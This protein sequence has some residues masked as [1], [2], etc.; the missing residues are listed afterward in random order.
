[1]QPSSFHLPKHASY[2]VTGCT[3]TALAF[4]FRGSRPTLSTARSPDLQG[5][6]IPQSAQRPPGR[7]FRWSVW[8]TLEGLT[9]D[10]GTPQVSRQDS[11]LQ[12]V[13]PVASTILALSSVIAET[14]GRPM[15]TLVEFVRQPIDA[16]SPGE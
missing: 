15:S 4:E 9:A 13:A 10:D 8:P 14:I 7:G 11:E 12:A 1:M 2:F 6:T 16:D 5:D 3:R